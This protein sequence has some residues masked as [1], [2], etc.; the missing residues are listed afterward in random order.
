MEPCYQWAQYWRHTVGRVPLPGVPV[1]STRDPE[2]GHPLPC[3]DCTADIVLEE[4]KVAV[5][6]VGDEAGLRRRDVVSDVANIRGQPS[7][8]I[9]APAWSAMGAPR[10]V[11]SGAGPGLPP[12][13]PIPVGRGGPPVAAP[14]AGA[15]G[16]GAVAMWGVGPSAP[17]L[18]RGG[19][20]GAPLGRG[21]AT[22]PLVGRPSRGA[23]GVGPLRAP[24]RR[25]GGG[26]A[27]VLTGRGPF[28]QE[29]W[30]R[31]GA[32]SGLVG[33]W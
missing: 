1:A 6:V 3:C 8:G 23:R 14:P 22:T 5:Q 17:P 32:A 27:W 28:G 4:A 2:V 26:H 7:R 12:I 10:L 16:G 20:S 13:P 21:G 19:P 33:V 9:R 24:V 18:G 15:G 29:R 11:G 30:R 25:D 31:E